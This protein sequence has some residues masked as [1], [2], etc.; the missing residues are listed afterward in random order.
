VIA[1]EDVS[2]Q[3][4]FLSMTIFDELDGLKESYKIIVDTFLL[5]FVSVLDNLKLRRRR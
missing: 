3:E 4:M 5:K 1:N 2:L